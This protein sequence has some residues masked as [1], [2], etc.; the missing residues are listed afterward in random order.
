MS[1]SLLVSGLEVLAFS[2][3]NLLEI[4]EDIPR[5]KLCYQPFPGANHA[6]WIMGHLANSDEFF[7]AELG[8]RPGANFEQTKAL[9]FA[10]SK[11]T[12]HLK[13][14]PPLEEIKSYL[15][16]GRE[17]LV[18]WFKSLSP[19]QLAAPLPENWKPFA[20]TYGALMFS[21]AWHEGLHTGQLTA[22]RKSL[23][24]SPK[25]G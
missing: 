15:S 2:R 23:G 5:D 14:Y 8:K 22:I 10:G 6:L 7:V 19:A 3:K 25:F 1:E 21:I 9:F 11:P 20:S 13:D 12:P 18:S 24:L 17:S 16:A 4:A